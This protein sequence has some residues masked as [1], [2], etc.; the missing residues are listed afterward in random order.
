MIL[1]KNIFSLETNIGASYVPSNCMEPMR[2]SRREGEYGEGI[3][4]KSEMR[5]LAVHVTARRKFLLMKE[6]M[7]ATTYSASLISSMAQYIFETI[8]ISLHV[9]VLPY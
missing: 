6:C 3:N 5:R 1:H 7:N 8:Q 9:R 2:P 4:A